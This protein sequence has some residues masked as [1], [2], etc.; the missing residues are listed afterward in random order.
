MILDKKVKYEYKLKKSFIF[1][2][3][4]IKK[5]KKNWRNCLLILIIDLID[6]YFI[7]FYR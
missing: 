1:I 2:G 4:N 7:I 3:I 5:I 6:Y